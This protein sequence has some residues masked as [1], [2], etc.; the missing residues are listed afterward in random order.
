MKNAQVRIC[1]I[2][3]PLLMNA[4]NLCAQKQGL[5]LIDSLKTALSGTSD[6][7][8]KVNLL[9]K[10]TYHYSQINMET[11]RK[12]ADQ[13]LTLAEEIKWEK[14]IAQAKQV[15]GRNHWQNG[16]FA[17]ALKY[18]FEA[19]NIFQKLNITGSV[20]IVHLFIAQDYADDGNYFEALKYL[21][22]SLEG[23][24]KTGNQANQGVVHNIFAWV[25]DNLG[26][27]PDA[28]KHSYA[29][30]KI[31]EDTG[32]KHGFAIQS[33]SMAENLEEQGKF[34]EAVKIYEQTIQALRAVDDF[35]N[36]SLTYGH[37]ARCHTRMRNYPEALK[38][39]RIAF[40]KGKKINNSTC[41]ASAYS[42][43]GDIWA[44]QENYREALKNY[45][46]AD[47]LFQVV[48]NK[49]SLTGLYSKIGACYVRA[50]NLEASKHF[51]DKALQFGKEMESIGELNNYYK[52]IV[53][54]DS[55][56][57]NWKNAF[58]HFKLYTFTRDSIY[59]KEN[60]KKMVQIRMQYAFDKKEAA[61]KAEQEKKDALA[62]QEL[63][64]Q[65]L[66]RNG[67]MGGFVI[68]MLFAGVFFYQRNRIKKG[69]KLSD[70]LLLNILPAEVADELKAKGSADAKLID[71]VTV[72]FSDFK[73][74]TQLSET[75]TPEALVAEIN[76]CFSA[77]DM[78]MQKHGVEKI[79]TV[80]DAYLA[81]G[82]LPVPNKDHAVRVLNAAIDMQEFM[83]QRKL[84]REA[85][86][87]FFFEARIGVHSGPVVAG[88][89]GIK[90]FAYDIWG[91]TVNTAQRMESSGEPGKVNISESTFARVNTQF[92]CLYR[93]MI[94][95]KGKGEVGMYFVTP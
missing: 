70:E 34:Q 87:L 36:E 32:D 68:V 13:A 23:F 19:L 14:G 21:G 85:D 91:D 27:Y 18:H 22:K 6:D 25:Y 51:F 31:F 81:A 94:S 67:F 78:I 86:G 72:L 24:E 76:A 95:T 61:V 79:K 9:C 69:K 1:F 33:G 66:V 45:L 65:K 58:E 12:Y 93:G 37:I 59:N 3:L 46:S 43:V 10:L 83:Q 16:K 73:D 57:G 26:M 63:Q 39:Y 42:G 40:E 48:A 8:L 15:I 89:V 35:I 84:R 2:L 52:S 47:Q 5:A 88:I 29:A 41:M 50:G 77:F 80:G 53:Q 38:Y 64:K 20:A 71:E 75:L 60:T 49:P 56:K 4:A 55:A 44:D 92:K 62:K 17:E 74:F 11:S 30:L 82:G 54:F 7:T 28:L 90:K